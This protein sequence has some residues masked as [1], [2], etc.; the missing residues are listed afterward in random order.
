YTRIFYSYED[1]NGL[2][3]V[4]GKKGYDCAHS[5]IEYYYDND[6]IERSLYVG[7][8]TETYSKY[9]RTLESN[10]S[11]MLKFIIKGEQPLSYFD[12]QVDNMKKGTAGII[13]N[14]INNLLGR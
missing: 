2:T 10:V 6:L 3:M 8:D 13:L 14:E 9:R 5:V 7:V 11:Q 1:E 12:Q 4:N